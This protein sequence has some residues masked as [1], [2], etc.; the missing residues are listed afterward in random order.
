MTDSNSLKGDHMMASWYLEVTVDGHTF[1]SGHAYTL[2]TALYCAGF[3][4]DYCTPSASVA[5][6]CRM[7]AK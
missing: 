2:G 3:I 6:V 1:S 7:V 4:A 5:V